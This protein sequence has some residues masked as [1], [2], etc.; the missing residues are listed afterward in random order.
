MPHSIQ[1]RL[2]MA[3]LRG[4]TGAHFRTLFDEHFGGFD[5]AVAPFITTVAASSAARSHFRDIL[6]ENNP[7]L[8][9]V[10]QLIGKDGD[11]FARMARVVHGMGYEEINWNLGCPHPV[12]TRKGRGS[13]L[14]PHPDRIRAFLDT[15]VP[16]I[17]CRL[18]VKV[19]LGLRDPEE[20]RGVTAVLNDYPLS[21]VIVHPRTGSQMYEGE[22]DLA[23]YGEVIQV[24][25]HPVIYNGDITAPADLRLLHE[26][27]P[28]TAGW[29]IGR[30]AVSNPFL[31]SQIRGCPLPPD[32]QRRI[33]A[34][35]DA[36]Y[37]R[38]RADF[39]GPAPL[40]G[41]MKELWAY[42]SQGLEDGPRLLKKIRKATGCAAYERVVREH[43][44]RGGGGG[45][46]SR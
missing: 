8:P 21:E 45:S 38:Y 9:L 4:T 14:L 27:F 32:P 23:R 12:V 7:R 41:A 16:R 26:R 44:A 39:S 15:A 22:V 3:P 11:D 35:H 6:P 25:R 2:I 33:E 36:L 19:R 30:G 40:L 18:S 46:R 17:P 1:P 10:P 43:F 5:R 34:F 29:M 28:S 20:L 13:G 37:D 42:L 31:P 24:C